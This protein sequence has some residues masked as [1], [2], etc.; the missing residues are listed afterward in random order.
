MLANVLNTDTTFIGAS[1]NTTT[2]MSAAKVR[3]AR[4]MS[5]SDSLQAKHQLQ[6]A[7]PGPAP[8]LSCFYLGPFKCA[9]LSNGYAS[10]GDK[11]HCV[12]RPLAKAEPETLIDFPVYDAFAQTARILDRLE[13]DPDTLEVPGERAIR[14]LSDGYID[15]GLR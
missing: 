10:R 6:P 2:P 15:G 7:P 14:L 5:R 1:A 11:A 4:S 9:S 3:P 12:G 13:S 8:G